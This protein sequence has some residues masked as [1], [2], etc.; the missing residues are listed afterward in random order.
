[1]DT[2]IDDRFS[3]AKHFWS[4]VAVDRPKTLKK[5]KENIELY[6][7]EG[8]FTD[9]E[10]IEHIVALSGVYP[11][12]LVANE[13]ILNKLNEKNI[14]PI[15]SSADSPD[16]VFWWFIPRKREIKTTKTGKPYWII[17]VTDNTNTLTEIK[18]WSI[19]ETDV[20]HMNRLYMAQ[21]SRDSYG[22]SIKNWKDHVRLLS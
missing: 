2:L 22:Y 20:V 1:L 14:K 7:P 4:A 8:N 12:N 3:G 6:K 5:F 19:R 9:E 17:E 11:L 13:Q 15:G 10:K 16:S 21:V 18:C